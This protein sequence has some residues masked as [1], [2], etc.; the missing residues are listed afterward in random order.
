MPFVMG[1]RMAVVYQQLP[2]LRDTRTLHKENHSMMSMI[3]VADVD[4]S[5]GCA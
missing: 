4:I 2:Q 1:G 5:V 3:I